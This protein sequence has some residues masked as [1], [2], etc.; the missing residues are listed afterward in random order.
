[1]V[2]ALRRATTGLAVLLVITALAACTR[3]TTTAP[4]HPASIS[5]GLLAPGTGPDAANG[6]AAL[7]GAQLAM[8]L[9]NGAFP[10]L[11]LPLATGMSGGMRVAIASGDTHSDPAAASEQ[12]VRLSREEHVVGV[13]VADA[14]PVAAAV[15][16]QADGLRLPTVDACSS[17]DA[18][19]NSGLDWYFRTGPNDRMLA[20]TAFALMRQQRGDQ[21]AGR[22]LALLEG[23]TGAAADPAAA[24]RQFADDEGYETVVRLP[25]GSTSTGADLTSKLNQ[26][27]PDSVVAIV[28]S[29]TEA[30]VVA[31]VAQRLRTVPVL[32]LGHGLGPLG[33]GGAPAGGA[34]GVL[35]SVGW[36]PDLVP[37][38]PLAKEVAD[39]YQRRFATPMS[40]VAANVFTAVLALAAGV[41][42]AAITGS[43]DDAAHIRAAMRQLSLPASKTIMPWN[44]VRF[45][46]SGQN[47]LAAGVVEQRAAA[48]FQVV[49]PGELATTAVSWRR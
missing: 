30:A 11:S 41:D 4:K 19:T 23:G 25:V 29:E 47:Q 17:A 36:S 10:A 7:Q 3:S 15:G 46:A 18:L 22:R 26:A 16:H 42:A 27:H 28:G 5:I 44:G 37:H 49:Y 45:D 24:V 20:E 32:V 2:T 43:P 13:V 1:V 9:L 12:A 33:A 39:L 14:A 6:R 34:R 48:G 35:R 31:D 38:N 40:D 21:T 8:E